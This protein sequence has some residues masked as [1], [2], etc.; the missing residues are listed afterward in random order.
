M[1]LSELTSYIHTHIPL[2]SHLGAIVESYDGDLM[3]I[4]APLEANL[5]HR[6]T[7]FG[8]SISALG[9]LSGWALL[10]IKL[11]ESDLKKKLVIQRSSCDFIEPIDKDFI[12]I[13][14][15]PNDDDWDKFIRTLKR[16][17][18]ARISI[19]SQ[20]SSINEIGGKHKGTYVAILL[21]K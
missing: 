6:N 13:C 5:N 1:T 2:T 19:D 15:K 20:I 3:E 4:S 18:K 8:G 21:E 17:G 16:H 7:A 10:F 11:K 9:I 14:R 12:A